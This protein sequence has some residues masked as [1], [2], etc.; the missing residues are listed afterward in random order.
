MINRKL[1]VALSF[2]ILF[3]MF[4]CTPEH[5]KIIV[6]EYD[7]DAITMGEFENAYVK[8]AG[9]V[10]KARKDSLEDYKNFLDLLVNYKMKLK[11]AYKRG[12]D[13]N[14][15]LQK[16]MAQYRKNIAVT[17]FL[18]K[19]LVDKGIKK[20]YEQRKNEIRVSHIMI[21]TDTL[22]D[23]KAKERAYEVLKKLKQGEKFEDLVKQYSDDK[24]SVNQ[25]GDVYYFVAG[26][27]LADFE[28]AAYQTP[29]DSVYPEPVKTRF[30]YHII[31]VTDKM[32]YRPEIR[33]SHILVATKDKD[34]R[35]KKDQD[36]LLARIKAIRERALQG[37]DFA[38]LAKEYSDD[39]ISKKRGGDLGFFARRRMVKPF[40]DAAFKLKKGEISGI[41]KTPYGYHIIKL[42][43]EKPYPSF[44]ASKSFLKKVYEKTRYKR[45]LDK[46]VA[47][48]AKKYNLKTVESTVNYILSLADTL[49]FPDYFNSEMREKVKD[50][51]LFTFAG[52]NVICDTVFTRL[53]KDKSYN[54]WKINKRFL[55]AAIKKVSQELMLEERVKNLENEDPGFATLMDEYRNG[56]YIFELQ[57]RE[58][59]DKLKIDS[60]DIYNYYLA[61]KDKYFTTD[62]VD[63]SEIF[64]RNDSLINLYYDKLKSGADFDSLAE[65]VTERVGYKR[66]KGHFGNIEVMK[67]ELAMKAA[68]LEKPGEFTRPFKYGNGWSIVKLNKRERPRQKTFDEARAQAASDLQ[69]EESKRLE[70]EYID[71]LKS[72]YQPVYYYEKLKNAFRTAAK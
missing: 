33:A 30:G 28:D 58:V 48:L 64:S 54:N 2:I 23:E 18:D 71:R 19:E 47:Q 69:D 7:D 40:D 63:F 43:D 36:A 12:L 72:I 9:S 11:D 51:V 55:D 38:E 21:K 17:W 24:Y 62:K 31:K 37:E 59:W 27:I 8:N 57:K 45:D 60:T 20:L 29:V 49:K 16:E 4:A 61:H 25:G 68:T 1:L 14:P 26:E 53:K 10:E 42:T 67:N 35:P 56:L 70:N 22:S 15:D 32:P 65:K 34:G 39:T 13:K 50:K 44:E 3:G 52:N 46:L 6:A 41:V 5:S 66:K